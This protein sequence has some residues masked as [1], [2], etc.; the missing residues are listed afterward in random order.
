MPGTATTKPSRIFRRCNRLARVRQYLAH[1]IR[2]NC[3]V[4]KLAP[5]VFEKIRFIHHAIA[6]EH[7]DAIMESLGSSP[8]MKHKNYRLDR[9]IIMTED[10]HTKISKLDC[11]RSKV[12]IEPLGGGMTNVNFKVTDNDKQYVVRLGNDDP[13]HLI[14]RSNELASN[15]AAFE[16]GVSPELVYHE[17]GVMVVRFI[18]G[19]VFQE[20]DIR[21]EVNLVRIIELLRPGIPRT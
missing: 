7:V 12:D 10:L 5:A 9:T 14:S 3:I 20:A 6:R 13:V 21:D 17:A 8:L 18:E 16:A 1:P 2:Q 11:W 4:F 19:K 15:K